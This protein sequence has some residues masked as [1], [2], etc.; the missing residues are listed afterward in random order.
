[1]HLD[2]IHPARAKKF[3]R[4]APVFRIGD[5]QPVRGARFRAIDKRPGTKDV[6]TDDVAM[7]DPGAHP[8]NQFQG[9]AHVAHPSD[10]IRDERW[11]RQFGHL[12][13]MNMNVPKAGN[14]E[15]SC[16]ID[17][18]CLTRNDPLGRGLHRGETPIF[19]D[20]S[21]VGLGE[22]PVPSIRVTF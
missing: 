7:T 12:S 16:A 21:R 13:E 1:M 2:E 5:D 17:D 9:T 10:P 20:D 3:N 14:R 18:F 11:T 19:D 8:I 15:L 22:A 4:L 6:R